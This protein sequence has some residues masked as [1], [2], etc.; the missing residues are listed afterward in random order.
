MT[1]EEKRKRRC[2]R[3]DER[4][5]LTLSER[6]SEESGP[7][8]ALGAIWLIVFVFIAVVG[9]AGF[10][11]VPQVARAGGV[12]ATQSYEQPVQ[13]RT[14]GR[15]A[16]L[17]VREGETVE[18]GQRL[19]RL[20]GSLLSAEQ[21]R[22]RSQLVGLAL[23][24]ER[25]RA[26]VEGRE[27]DFAAIEGAA[28]AQIIEARSTLAA[29]REALADRERRAERRIRQ[30]SAEQEVLRS[31]KLTRIRQLKI[32]EARRDRVQELFSRSVASR[33][34]VEIAE[35]ELVAAEGA[36]SDVEGRLNLSAE[37]VREAEL[38]L[39]SLRSGDRAARMEAL[40][41]VERAVGEQTAA[42]VAVRERLAE[43]EIVAPIGGV[44]KGLGDIDVD[45][46]LPAG[47]ALLSLVPQDGPLVA[48]V[49]LDPRDLGRIKIG[50]TA[51][52][53]VSAFDP[54]RFGSAAG[55]LESISA[56]S[57]V[58]DSG[59]VYFEAEIS[60]DRE[61]LGETPGDLQIRAGMTVVAEIIN[62]ER[63]LLEYF[64]SPILSTLS[65]SFG[66]S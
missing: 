45:R 42:L 19:A 40:A 38:A 30:R 52:V 50:Q 46:V 27:A 53:Q 64:L 12:V 47:G 37:S 4:R 32:A 33:A 59:R 58:D 36:L 21:D 62:S 20:D 26:Y 57:F 17:L 63:T 56:S 51:Q 8:A 25:L 55:R 43:L 28:S 6:L 48:R 60:L 41:D 66:E 24:A 1:E 18:A 31:E 10:A 49:E 54:V 7:L 23:Q 39:I 34:D 44:V 14:G 29:M 13:H 16:E 11:R 5:L 3:R 35:R 2:V 9:W 15:I 22:I 65:S 61:Y